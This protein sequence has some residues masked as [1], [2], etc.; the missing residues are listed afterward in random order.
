MLQAI[1]AATAAASSGGGPHGM[2]IIIVIVII[3]AVVLGIRLVRRRSRRGRVND[4]GD[5]RNGG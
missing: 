3:A 1:P 4:A 5:T 2:R